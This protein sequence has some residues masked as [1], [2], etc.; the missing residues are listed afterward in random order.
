VRLSPISISG[1]GGGR[2]WSGRRRPRGAGWGVVGGNVGGE[3]EDEDVSAVSGAWDDGWE[4][5][6]K[7]GGGVVIGAGVVEL[8]RLAGMYMRCDRGLRTPPQVKA[9]TKGDEEVIFG[10][11]ELKFVGEREI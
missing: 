3:F 5:V 7:E 2:R 11:F 9:T 4:G 1:S 10:Y 6:F 8:R